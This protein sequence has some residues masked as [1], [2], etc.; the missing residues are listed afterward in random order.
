MSDI[1]RF[2][3][4]DMTQMGEMQKK[5]QALSKKFFQAIQS[6]NPPAEVLLGSCAGVA[7][8][9]LREIPLHK[10]AQVFQ[11]FMESVRSEVFG[12]FDLASGNVP[13]VTQPTPHPKAG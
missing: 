11:A 2:T 8:I 6:M 9:A 1:I 3:P 5:S 13:V 12:Q 7:A 10:R 4:Q